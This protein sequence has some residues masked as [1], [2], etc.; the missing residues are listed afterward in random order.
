MLHRNI[1]TYKIDWTITDDDLIELTKQY[2]LESSKIYDSIANLKQSEICYESIVNVL[3]DEYA[4]MNYFNNTASFLQYVLDNDD[5]RQASIT[6]SKLLNEY[7]ILI[8]SRID[9]YNKINAYYKGIYKNDEFK[10][11]YP[12][13][14]KF[15][16]K[17]IDNYNRNGVALDESNKKLLNEISIRITDL[18]TDF[19][20]NLNEENTEMIFS[21]DEL[22]GLSPDFLNK[23]NVSTD[24]EK[25]IVDNYINDKYSV[26]LK[27]S[28]YNPCMKRVESEETRKK[29]EYKFN[30]R[31]LNEN[32]KIL[33]ELLPLRDK[34]AKL[35]GYENHLEY[36]TKNLVAKNGK[37]VND[38]IDQIIEKTNSA[39]KSDINEL[40]K[41]KSKNLKIDINDVHIFPYDIQYYQELLE[42]QDYNVDKNKLREYFPVDHV[43]NTIFD[44]YQQLFELKF[45]ESDKPVWH[46]SVKAYSMYEDEKFIGTFYLDLFPR[47]N[48]YGHA[49]CFPLQPACSLSN[50]KL[51]YP[52]SAI[53]CNFSEPTKDSPGLL[54]YNEVITFFHEFG[55]VIH[56]LLGRTKFS[57]FSGSNTE[58]DFVEAPSQMLENWCWEKESI[59]MLSKHYISGNSIDDNTI[60]NLIKSKNILNGLH[61]RKQLY[62]TRFDLQVH[63]DEKIIKVLQDSNID[64]KKKASTLYKLSKN[65]HQN[66]TSIVPTSNTFQP[67]SFGHIA[68]GYDAQYYSYLWSVIYASDMYHEKFKGNLFN[69]KIGREY[70]NNVLKKGG[71]LTGDKLFKNFVGRKVDITNFLISKELID[72]ENLYVLTSE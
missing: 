48:K 24:D 19:S 55:H 65:I 32:M 54:D 40:K 46:S 60:D 5:V 27:Y 52:V 44:I 33:I 68:G 58:M 21:K 51:I 6:C 3:Q 72:E 34:K 13:D 66:M 67:A 49:A 30:T 9:V 1:D 63:S 25:K 39:I 53:V 70:K 43:I 15:I 29:L 23:L 10:K 71:V 14:Y 56:Q 61:L 64:M 28:V 4:I 11:K 12:E 7:F 45:E 2:I 20:N 50:K 62:L 36:I 69:A 26:N 17:I 37:N 47:M 22:K 8:N 31:C 18:E 16:E 38:M 35:L 42:K 41:L 59:K 57:L